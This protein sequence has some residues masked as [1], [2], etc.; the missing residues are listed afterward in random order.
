L[1]GGCCLAILWLQHQ[2]ACSAQLGYQA[3]K[4][5]LQRLCG[6]PVK[7]DVVHCNSARAGIVQKWHFTP[8]AEPECC[9]ISCTMVCTVVSHQ[10]SC[11]RLS[12][13]YTRPFPGVGAAGDPKPAGVCAWDL[14]VGW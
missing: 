14:C 2:M 10:G 12:A 11:A 9:N 13:V 6:F 3:D 1:A 8:P 7:G 4:E 5:H